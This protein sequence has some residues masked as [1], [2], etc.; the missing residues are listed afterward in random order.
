MFGLSHPLVAE[1][2]AELA[3]G[4]IGQGELVAARDTLQTAV[5]V[6]EA[7]YPPEHPT[8]LLSKGRLAL[9]LG[10]T[11]RIERSLAMFDEVVELESKRDETS[12][13]LAKVLTNR[14]ILLIEDGRVREAKADL[15]RALVIR[16]ALGD[17]NGQATISSELA[18][19][20]LDR[21]D[22]LTA[23]R[24]ARESIAL[25]EK[26]AGPDHPILS[27]GIVILGNALFAQPGRESEARA[28]YQRG[29]DL[30]EKTQGPEHLNI[31]FSLAG[32][33]RLDA[34]EGKVDR[35]RTRLERSVA[36]LQRADFGAELEFECRLE[37][38]SLDWNADQRDTARQH[39]KEA[40]EDAR[41]R[42]PRSMATIQAWLREHGGE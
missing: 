22:P 1:A 35:A 15:D 37:L 34:R 33:G 10:M 28:T 5:T 14:A 42:H 21:E 17:E 2:L 8:M 30:V 20:A 4:W 39:A 19:I 29:L 24:L 40:L 26:T 12:S 13:D 7:T 3:G 6:F 9:L 11:G 18:N 23:E 27:P 38:A 41:R 16:K 36:L 31:A 32:L 25:H